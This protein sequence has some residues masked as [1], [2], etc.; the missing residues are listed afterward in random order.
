MA[1]T[2]NHLD[3]DYLAP[4][5]LKLKFWECPKKA[6]SKNVTEMGHS[7]MLISQPTLYDE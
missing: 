1:P 7:I 4:K 6:W 3:I 5:I 2:D